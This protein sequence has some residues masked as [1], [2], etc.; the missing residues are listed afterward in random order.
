MVHECRLFGLQA[1]LIMLHIGYLC[2]PIN[3]LRNNNLLRCRR[4]LHLSLHRLNLL[5]SRNCNKLG[6][7]LL[8]LQTQSLLLKLQGRHVL[9]YCWLL[10]VRLT[11]HRMWLVTQ[12]VCHVV[13]E[14]SI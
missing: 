2:R 8:L 11:S 13:D 12:H 6:R 1:E 7:W 9:L 4:L 3:N 14:M 5:R 10:L